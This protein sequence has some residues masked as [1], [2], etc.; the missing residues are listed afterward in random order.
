MAEFTLW[1]LMT[2]SPTGALAVVSQHP[3]QAICESLRQRAA[4]RLNVPNNRMTCIETTI[5]APRK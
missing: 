5:V 2:V 3:T 1:L 4:V